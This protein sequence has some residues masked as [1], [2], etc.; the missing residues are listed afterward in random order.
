M[1]ACVILP[2]YNEAENVKFVIP[3]IFAQ[4]GKIP[5]HELHVLVV[6]DNSPDGDAG[7]CL[8]IDETI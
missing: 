5:S 3:R 2:T 7:C 6:D 4:A 8:R 1:K